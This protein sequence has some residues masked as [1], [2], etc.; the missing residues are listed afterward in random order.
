[1]LTLAAVLTR[2]LP[3]GQPSTELDHELLLAEREHDIY[4]M[5]AEEVDKAVTVSLLV[6]AFVVAADVTLVTSF[7]AAQAIALMWPLML[8][9]IAVIATFVASLVPAAEADA[10]PKFD[11]TK[12]VP[13]PVEARR[14]LLERIRSRS[15]ALRM[16]L[17]RRRRWLSLSYGAALA[18]LL[19][20]FGGV[21]FSLM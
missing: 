6:C 3:Q 8:A 17:V 5:R 4:K 10:S 9:C 19:G 13:G 20:L 18:S 7:D 14:L 1:M 2:L 11:P 12:A 15:E 21:A 16:G